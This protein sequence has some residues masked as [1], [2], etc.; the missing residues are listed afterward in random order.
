MNKVRY[1]KHEIASK[2]KYHITIGHLNVMGRL[3][4]FKV[5][6]GAF[7]FGK[8]YPYVEEIPATA[9]EVEEGIYGI[10][11]LDK[12]C[13]LRE[14]SFFIGSRLELSIDSK[15]CRMAFCGEALELRL[16]PADADFTDLQLSKQKQKAGEIERVANDNSLIVKDMFTKSSNI[17]RYINHPIVLD[18][19]PTLKAK[20][21]TTFGNVGKIKVALGSM[22]PAEEAEGL[23]GTKCHIEYQK[24]IKFK[25]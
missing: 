21:Q 11:F 17:Q 2:V 15:E 23:V 19:K 13:Y 1:W 7:E 12:A 18:S 4:L 22:L 14:N 25:V 16:H 24:I 8:V 6:G 5:E 3:F 20:I 10:I 9:K